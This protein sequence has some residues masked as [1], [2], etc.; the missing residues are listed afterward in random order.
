MK[1]LKEMLDSGVIEQTVS[2]WSSP[3]VVVQKKDG[4]VRLCVDYRQLNKVSIFDAYPMPR[5]SDVIDHLGQKSFIATLDLNQSY[6]QVPMD[7]ASR[8]KTA[9]SSPLSLFQ[10]TVMP[11]S[12]CGAPATFQRLMDEVLRGAGDYSAAYLD[13]IIVRSGVCCCLEKW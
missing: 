7:P 3:L 12:L 10:F 6:W 9:F 4:G 13:D 2:E 1:E 5:V 8:Q 11:F